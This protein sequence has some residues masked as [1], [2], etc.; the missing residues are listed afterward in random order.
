MVKEESREAAHSPQD[1]HDGNRSSKSVTSNGVAC[2]REDDALADSKSIKK[3]EEADCS[4]HSK[5]LHVSGNEEVADL[6]DGKVDKNEQKREQATKKNRRKLSSST[7]SAKLPECQVVA[8]EKEADKMDSENH[9]KEVVSSPHKD[10]F[11]ERARPSENDEEIQAKIS[12]PKACNDESEAVASPSPS[13]SLPET[14]SEKH[15]KAKTEDS[16]ANVEVAEVVSKK[17]SEGASHSEAKPVKRLV[18]KALGRNSDVRKTAGADSGK[19]RSGAASGADSKKHS[20]KKLDENEGGG[21]SS[22]QLVDKKKLGREEA[23]SEKGAAK[24]STL[25]ADKVLFCAF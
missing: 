8:N 3:K 5:G 21:S 9:S 1:N 14:H 12:L 13:D 11:V 20:A 2:V 4:G 25:D 7:K 15:G 6:D 18:K 24:S 16:P 19:K 10:H 22:R 17:V 23:N